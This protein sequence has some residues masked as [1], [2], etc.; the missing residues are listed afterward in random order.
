MSSLETCFHVRSVDKEFIIVLGSFR[1]I[2]FLPKNETFIG[3]WRKE[4]HWAGNLH[5]QELMKCNYCKEDQAKK[6]K[7]NFDRLASYR[8]KGFTNDSCWEW[9]DG[10]CLNPERCWGKK[11]RYWTVL[12]S[13]TNSEEWTFKTEIIDPVDSRYTTLDELG[14]TLKQGK[15]ENRLIYSGLCSARHCNSFW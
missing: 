7:I 4:C 6:D 15:N 5:T 10:E 11:E 12:K 14:V 1:F 13:K 9:F 3:R 8:V 2:D